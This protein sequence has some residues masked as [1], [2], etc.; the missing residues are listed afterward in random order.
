MIIGGII[1]G[2]YGI[3]FYPENP[4]LFVILGISVALGAATNNPIAAIFIIVEMTWVPLLF[5]PVGITTVAAY[6]IS[7]P[8][9]IIPGQFDVEKQR[10]FY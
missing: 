9:S 6:L 5:I 4:E 8:N 7:G 1:C 10:G 3:V 2:L